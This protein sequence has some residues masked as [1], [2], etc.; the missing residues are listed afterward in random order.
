MA[1]FLDYK[2][3]KRE[4]GLVHDL[5][6]SGGNDDEPRIT[7]S[8]HSH[9]LRY[10]CGRYGNAGACPIGLANQPGGAALARPDHLSAELLSDRL[11]LR[12]PVRTLMP[13]GLRRAVNLGGSGPAD[14]ADTGPDATAGDDAPR[15]AGRRRTT[16]MS[17]P[18]CKCCASL[19]RSEA[20]N[21]R[22]VTSVTA[23]PAA[24]EY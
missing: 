22:F 11:R 7:S 2:W 19:R 5:Q 17:V 16:A 24:R 10:A 15:C 18:G 13:A 9:D 4:I 6:E 14:G 12:L 1:A 3:R 8:R 20:K 23:F 21:R